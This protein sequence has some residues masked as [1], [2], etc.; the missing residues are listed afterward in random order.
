MFILLGGLDLGQL[1]FGVSWLSGV[2]Q[3]GQLGQQPGQFG[4]LGLENVPLR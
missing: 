1:G 3:L 4:Q 2:D